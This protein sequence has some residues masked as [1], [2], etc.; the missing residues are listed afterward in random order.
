MVLT[1][2]L[3]PGREECNCIEGS[4]MNEGMQYKPG[5]KDF[6]QKREYWNNV[7][8]LEKLGRVGELEEQRERERERARPEEMVK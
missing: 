6:F 1:P 5:F 4:S 7:Y 2:C 3:K 8:I